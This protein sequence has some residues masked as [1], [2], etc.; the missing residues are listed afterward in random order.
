MRID[1][2]TIYQEISAELHA[3]ELHASELRGQLQLIERLLNEAQ[4]PIMSGDPL[5]EQAANGKEIHS[6][7]LV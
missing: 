6:G 4:Q 5:G 1:L 2:A 7:P 3:S